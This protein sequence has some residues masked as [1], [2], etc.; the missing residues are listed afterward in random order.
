MTA[1]RNQ[2]LAFLSTGGGTQ[3]IYTA[4]ADSGELLHKPI[5]GGIGHNAVNHKGIYTLATLQKTQLLNGEWNFGFNRNYDRKVA[6]PGLISDPTQATPGTAWFK[7]QLQRPP[8]VQYATLILSGARFAPAVYIDGEKQSG[9]EGG[10]AP[11]QHRLDLRST[12]ETF[13]LELAL[14][15]MKDLDP[16]DASMIPKADHWRSNLSSCLWDDVRLRFTGPSYIK[17]LYTYTADDGLIHLRIL[18]EGDDT[19]KSVRISI[20]DTD[21]RIILEH[22]TECRIGETRDLPIPNTEKLPEWSPEQPNCYVLKA[23]LYT[24]GTYTD[25]HRVNIAKRRF[26]VNGKR[27]ALN[28][29]EV[30]LRAGSIVWHRFLRD[31]EAP[32]LAWNMETL[33]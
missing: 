14:Q 2:R 33:C 21:G 12:S 30:T 6:V 13:D 15:S 17:R 24:A 18:T 3:T 19:K 4:N 32:D 16:R 27:F 28:G 1:A 29:R 31:P 8:H 20:E 11:T 10:M 23:D 5:V 7:R 26:Q 22:E 9:A 25:R